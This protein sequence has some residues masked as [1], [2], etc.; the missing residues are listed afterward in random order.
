MRGEQ[1]NNSRSS[2]KTG[3]LVTLSVTLLVTIYYMPTEAM[4]LLKF[5]ILHII[6]RRMADFV[7]NIFT[8]VCKL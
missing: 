4:S 1:R 5:L 8:A 6:L 2:V 7:Y 3:D